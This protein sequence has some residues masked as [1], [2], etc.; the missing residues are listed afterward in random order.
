MKIVKLKACME[1][2]LILLLWSTE[3]D[4]GFSI[5]E[6]V[7][8][9]GVSIRI[10]LEGVKVKQGACMESLSGDGWVAKARTPTPVV[11]VI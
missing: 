3:G 9:L 4:G 11:Q 1:S 7:A 6:W 10:S 5:C 8:I 2:L